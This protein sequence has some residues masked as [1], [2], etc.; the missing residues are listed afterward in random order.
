[1]INIQKRQAFQKIEM[2]LGIEKE[3]IQLV[4]TIV[5]FI[6][7]RSYCLLCMCVPYFEVLI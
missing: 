5:E 6:C 7:A 4:C 3:N 2:R 1:M